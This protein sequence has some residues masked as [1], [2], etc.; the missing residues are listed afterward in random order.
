[1]NGAPQSGRKASSDVNNSKDSD[2]EGNSFWS[3]FLGDSF[4]STTTE[5]K[6]STRR[7]SGH[8]LASRIS[9]GKTRN[10]DDQQDTKSVNTSKEKDNV[11]SPRTLRQ[12]EKNDFNVTDTTKLDE[13]LQ[14]SQILLPQQEEKENASRDLSNQDGNKAVSVDSQ[15]VKDSSPEKEDLNTQEISVVPAES[16]NKLKSQRSK[17]S[18]TRKS[19]KEKKEVLKTENNVCKD[20]DENVAIIQDA[21]IVKDK[22]AP[23]KKAA[24][25]NESRNSETVHSIPVE[26]MADSHTCTTNEIVLDRSQ[27]ADGVTSS[28]ENRGKVPDIEKRLESSDINTSLVIDLTDS[29]IADNAGHES[30][31]E[32]VKQNNILDIEPLASSTPNHYAKEQ[33]IMSLDMAMELDT[34]PAD[35]YKEA[36][37]QKGNLVEHA[38]HEPESPLTHSKENKSVSENVAELFLEAASVIQDKRL[39]A[40]SLRQ[41]IKENTCTHPET[42]K[43]VDRLPLQQPNTNNGEYKQ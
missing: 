40:S 25:K 14:A 15:A 34:K 32:R 13:Q 21:M 27:K 19:Q 11:L 16:G 38:V 1:M 17:R 36:V 28:K 9:G 3:S 10:S 4:S 18:P 26:T 2:S 31:Q 5:S 41:E 7:T 42:E 37:N 8:K 30:K 39:T 29:G 43:I 33:K 22:K 23:E 24:S 35:E 12:Q 20:N 6:T